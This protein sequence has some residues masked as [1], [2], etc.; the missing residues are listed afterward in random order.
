[1]AGGRL[2]RFVYFAA[3]VTADEFG[4]AVAHSFRSDE[5]GWLDIGFGTPP[6]PPLDINVKKSADP[7][8]HLTSLRDDPGRS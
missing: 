6:T 2:P 7:Y 4:E 1:M 5:Y 3:K 8:A